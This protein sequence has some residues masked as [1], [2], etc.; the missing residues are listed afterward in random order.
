MYSYIH[1]S[2]DASVKFIS[3]ILV[4]LHHFNSIYSLMLVGSL[5]EVTPGSEHAQNIVQLLQSQLESAYREY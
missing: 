5:M 1:V 4:N 2:K 3:V